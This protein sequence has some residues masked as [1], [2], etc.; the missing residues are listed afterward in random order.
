[1]SEIDTDQPVGLCYYCSKSVS[2]ESY[3]KHFAG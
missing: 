2:Q 1:M 3:V